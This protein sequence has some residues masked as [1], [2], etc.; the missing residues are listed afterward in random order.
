MQ[1]STKKLATLLLMLIASWAVFLSALYGLRLTIIFL[2][3][4][5]C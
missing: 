4:H 3:E 1:E 5:L 2:W